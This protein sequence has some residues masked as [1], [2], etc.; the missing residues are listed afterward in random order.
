M[1]ATFL[2]FH[3]KGEGRNQITMEEQQRKYPGITTPWFGQEAEEAEKIQREFEAQRE[4]YRRECEERKQLRRHQWLQ[5]NSPATFMEAGEGFLYDPKGRIS[6]GELYALYCGWCERNGLLPHPRR[7]FFLYVSRNAARYRLL[8]S[9]N[10]PT[11][12][13]SHI[14]GYLGI[15][16]IPHGDNM[17]M[18]AKNIRDP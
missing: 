4:R 2:R 10:I 5:A 6:S 12:K 11:E 9:C 16:P 13:G 8:H 7:A 14:N 18:A 15:R 3:P 17:E 1:D